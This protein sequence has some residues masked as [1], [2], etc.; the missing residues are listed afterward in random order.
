MVPLRIVDG[1]ECLVAKELERYCRY[2]FLSWVAKR[3]RKATFGYVMS[4]RRLPG[5]TEEDLLQP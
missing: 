1:H 3:L 5:A 4:V 2:L